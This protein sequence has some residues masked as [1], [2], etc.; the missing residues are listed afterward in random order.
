MDAFPK[1]KR[2]TIRRIPQ[3]ANFDRA[4][5]HAILDAGLICHVGFVADGLPYVI[6]TSY[7]REGERLYIHG[8]TASRLATTLASGVDVCVA[9]TLLDGLVLARS[10]FNHSMNYRS[11]VIFGRATAVENPADKLKALRLFTERVMPGRWNELRAPKEIELRATLVLELPIVE[12]SAKI[13]SGPP[14]D[15][16]DDMAAPVWAGVLPLVLRK[17]D[18]VPDST[19]IDPPEYLRRDERW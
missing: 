8:S 2:T 15:D 16:E 17:G 1:T 6:P 7:A 18:L 19:G 9:V 11:V 3:N 12:A 14:E 10:A 5:V 13:R 4:T